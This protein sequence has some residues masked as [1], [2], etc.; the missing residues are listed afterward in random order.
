MH[1]RSLGTRWLGLDTWRGPT[2][3]WTVGPAYDWDG[4]RR[5]RHGL[6]LAAGRRRVAVRILCIRAR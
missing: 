6:I 5:R 3:A 4:Y 1:A 2:D